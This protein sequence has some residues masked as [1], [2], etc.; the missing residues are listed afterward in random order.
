MPDK[1]SVELS[2]EFF[3]DELS[4][5]SS[6]AGRAAGKGREELKQAHLNSLTLVREGSRAV[7]PMPLQQDAETFSTQRMLWWLTLW[8]SFI[9]P[10]M[11]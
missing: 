4:S 9:C 6:V 5:P 1:L 11:Y 8:S 2:E 10:L 3:D 7:F